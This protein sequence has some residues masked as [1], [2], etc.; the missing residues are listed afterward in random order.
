MDA[1]IDISVSVNTHVYHGLEEYAASTG[2]TVSEAAEHI[3]GRLDSRQLAALRQQSL[4]PLY[5]VAPIIRLVDGLL[6]GDHSVA[7]CLA[8]GNFGLGTLNYLDG[9][10]AHLKCRSVGKQEGHVRLADVAA[11]QVTFDYHDE[12]NGLLVGFYCPEYVGSSV[13]VPGFH[14]HFLSEVSSGKVLLQEAE[15]QAEQEKTAALAFLSPA[16]AKKQK[17]RNALQKSE[18]FVLKSVE[19]AYGGSVPGSDNQ[20]LLADDDEEYSGRFCRFYLITA[21]AEA[22]LASLDPEERE[23]VLAA[24]EKKRRRA[25]KAARL[26][27]AQELLRSAGI[28]PAALEAAQADGSTRH[29]RR[30]GSSSKKRKHKHDAKKHRDK[31]DKSQKYKEYT[32][33]IVIH[34]IVAWLDAYGIGA[35]DVANSFGTS[36]GSKTLK[37]WSAVVIAAIF[38]FLG[39][40]LL[41]GQVTR[42]IAGSIAKT[43][44]FKNYPALFMFGMLTAETGAMIWILVATYIELP[45]STTHSIIGG[46]IGFALAFGGT[47]AVTWYEPRK[48]FPYVRGIVPIVASWFISPLAAALFCC[49]LF[50]LIRTLVLRRENSTKIAFYVLPVLI[51]LTIFVNLLF[52][53][54]KGVRGVVDIETDQAAWISAAAAGGSAIVGSLILWPVMKRFVRKYDEAHSAV[55]GMGKDGSR[56]G[57]EVVVDASGFKD[58]EEDNFQKK[59]DNELQAVEVDPNDKSFGAYMKR[60][61]NVAL[62]GM[63]HDIHKDIAE[64]TSL[65]QMHADAEKFDPRTEEV[66]KVLQ[67]LSAC[68]MAFAHGANDVANAIGSFAAALYVYYNF[69]VPGSN[70]AVYLWILALGGSGIV[71]GLATWGYNIMRV[72]GV[73]C[74]HITP[75]RGFCMELSTSFVIAVGSAYGLPL[76]TTQTICGATAGGGVAEGRWKA[77]NWLLYAKMFAG[78]V[79]TLLVTAGISAI[80]FLMGVHTPNQPDQRALRSYQDALLDSS[81]ASLAFLNSSNNALAN[82]NA[83]LAASISELGEDNFK[84]LNTSKWL[85]PKSVIANYESVNELFMNHTQFA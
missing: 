25:A 18:K 46:I 35:N 49:F 81:N 12:Q 5:V 17:D 63:N 10:F 19:G 85:K 30:G 38:E 16:E 52:I 69:K 64:D 70:S 11:A 80:L 78:W 22:L 79:F 72:L 61:R 57:N 39:A 75:S 45:V 9:S 50:V 8:K 58:V 34:G 77:L 56:T 15:W 53:L 13:N 29:Q 20:L 36:V 28:D 3:L 14:F 82:P 47:G 68:A 37:L 21:E 51:L 1:K 59:I 74:T 54:T 76:S 40:L 26:Q 33:M 32:W 43:S 42:T 2:R 66:F 44:T 83:D 24:L 4:V 67:V 60:F 62:A 41:G 71:V 55:G 7:E 31:D 23:A 27:Q 73:K 84:M 48:D 65:Q 6:A